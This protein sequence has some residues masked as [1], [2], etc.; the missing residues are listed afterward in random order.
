MSKRTKTIIRA[1]LGVVVAVDITLAAFSWQMADANRTPQSELNA[2]KR[3]HALMAADITRAETIRT[4]LPAVEQQCDSFFGQNFRPIASGYSSVV[5][6]FGSLSRGAGLQAGNLSFHQHEA[7]KRGVTQ[8][9]ISAVVDGDYSSVVRFINDLQHS[10]T[11]Y[12]LD[13]LSLAAPSGSGGQLKL[14]L[15][16]RTYFRS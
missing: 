12:V 4:T 6:D 16:L 5:S 7:D 2:L 15:L 1:I 9:D 13:G 10:D 3:Q 8:V 14:N 11:F